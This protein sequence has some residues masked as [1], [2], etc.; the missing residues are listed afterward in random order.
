MLQRE[1]IQHIV[2][3]QGADIFEVLDVVEF[4]RVVLPM[5]YKHRCMMSFIRQ[6]HMYG[7]RKV[8]RNSYLFRNVAFYV[9]KPIECIA[10]KRVG[11]KKEECKGPKEGMSMSLLDDADLSDDAPPPALWSTISQSNIDEDH[12][13]I[14]S[15]N[16]ILLRETAC[17]DL[18]LF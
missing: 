3:W 2:R 6:L 4:E 9:D 16:S 18:L 11:R 7:F 14:A 13:G 15:L 17:L 12:R 5:Y 8:K 1:D 10:R